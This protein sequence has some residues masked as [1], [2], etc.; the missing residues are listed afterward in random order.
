M[1]GF[2]MGVVMDEDE[3]RRDDDEDERKELE[4]LEHWSDYIRTGDE[5]KT[6]AGYL[7]WLDEQAWLGRQRAEIEEYD[8]A[9]QSERERLFR[10][11]R[12]EWEKL[13]NDGD[14]R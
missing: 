7:R 5:P 14:V 13:Q 1:A 9:A 4:R 10:E 2:D 3:R 12:V 6:R 11:R 8:H